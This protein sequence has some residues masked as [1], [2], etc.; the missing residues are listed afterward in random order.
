MAKEPQVTE[1]EV[2]K[3]LREQVEKV[4]GICYKWVSPNR[5]G[6][7]DRIVIFPPFIAQGQGTVWFIEVKKPGEEPSGS[8]KRMMHRLAK[9]GQLVGMVDTKKGVDQFLQK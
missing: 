2:E 1:K 7:P 8:Q 6:I 5:R 9:L 3:Y 4:G